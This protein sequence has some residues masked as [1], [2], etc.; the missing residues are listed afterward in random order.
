[1][2]KA[3]EKI[4]ARATANPAEALGLGILSGDVTA[5]QGALT[6][7]GEA[8]AAAKAKGA[9]TGAAT[10][11]AKKAAEARMHEA[12]ARIAGAGVL[13]FALSAGVRAE[14]EG[15]RGKKKG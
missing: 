1:M 5:L 15:L 3:G 9:P 13:A 7:L 10:A 2:V 8:E 4:V 12:T 11:K 14:F 6:A